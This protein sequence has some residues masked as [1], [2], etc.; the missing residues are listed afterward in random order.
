MCGSKHIAA[1]KAKAAGN[2]LLSPHQRRVTCP[3]K[4]AT[5]R[6]VSRKGPI[7]GARPTSR[8][9][10]DLMQLGITW[11]WTQL[12]WICLSLQQK[13][14]S[15]PP[16]K[17]LPSRGCSVL[18]SRGN[19][20][21]HRLLPSHLLQTYLFS[22]LASCC[23]LMLYSF[24]SSSWIRLFYFLIWIDWKNEEMSIVLI[25]ITRFNVINWR[26]HFHLII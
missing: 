3:E 16:G 5:Q 22:S 21:L 8:G 2:P 26:N 11:G 6:C 20:I 17:E 25:C 18:L 9:K 23:C 4:G 1:G 19:A 14:G 24:C 13:T 15:A 7:S 12:L 10:K